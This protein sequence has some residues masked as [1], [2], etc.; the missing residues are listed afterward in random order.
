MNI[1]LIGMAGSG[2]SLVG[3]ILAKKLHYEFIDV[4]KIIQKKTESRL[5][6]IV[7]KFG[8]KRFLEIEER[9]ILGL[10]L[11]DKCVISTGG[12]AIYS[13]KAMKYLKKCSIIVFLK[14]SFKNI[15]HWISN[16]STRGIIGFKKKGL[17]AL[18]NERMPLYKKY[19]DITVNIGED[20]NISH[21]A[22][23][24]ISKI[25]RKENR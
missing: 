4:D 21:I 1:T 23:N 11:E 14:A 19:A 2:K 3:K 18:F 6:T 24:I 7:D 12:S 10:D 9:S 16:K 22:E 17:K 20:S 8:E 13:K 15:D 5:Q 25:L